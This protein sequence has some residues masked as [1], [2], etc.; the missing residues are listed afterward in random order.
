MKC[1]RAI[2]NTIFNYPTDISW[3][4]RNCCTY[5]GSFNP[6]TLMERLEKGD[7]TIEPTDK[8][9]KIY[10]KGISDFTK[11]YFQHLSE[12]QKKRFIELL[13]EKKIKFDY[14]GYFYVKPFFIG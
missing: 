2:E 3:D 10:V 13:N 9:Y 8:N 11:F 1:P 5:C 6:D 14:P 4:A 7:I 12:D